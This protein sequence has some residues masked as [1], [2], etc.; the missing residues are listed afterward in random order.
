VFKEMFLLQHEVEWLTWHALYN[1][2]A[3]DE[4]ML[5]AYDNA[6]HASIPKLLGSLAVLASLDKIMYDNLALIAE[7]LF[8]FEGDTARVAIPVR[9]PE[10]R[11]S[12][13]KALA[14][15]FV[16]AEALWRG[17]PLKMAAV[18]EGGRTSTDT[19]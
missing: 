6:V 17:L 18:M 3:V 4:R 7:E 19:T 8:A 2:N 11:E 14:A 1:P 16:P 10:S 9:E 15:R 13:I 12:A 5:G